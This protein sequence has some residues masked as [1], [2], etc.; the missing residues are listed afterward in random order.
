MTHAG[1]KAAVAL[2]AMAV[3]GVAGI[4]AVAAVGLAALALV[5]PR[6][7]L[8]VAVAGAVFVA[9]NAGLMHLAL[10]D[11]AVGARAGLRG[12]AMFAVGAAFVARTAPR[13][14]LAALGRFPRVAVAL[15]AVLRMSP[16]VG[17]EA[18]R[19]S[20]AARL[21]GVAPLARARLAVPLVVGAARRGERFGDALALAGF[22]APHARYR[23]PP[24]R[25]TDTVVVLLA[26]VGALGVVAWT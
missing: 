15:A 12:A 18:R 26:V 13:E 19:L 21:K 22:P 6:R 17:R 7:A 23:R 3:A 4:P 20:D 10:G 24:W 11:A 14:A 25:R 1:A 8:A 2:A 5:P 16:D 9:W